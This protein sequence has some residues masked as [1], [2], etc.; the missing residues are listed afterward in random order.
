MAAMVVGLV[1]DWVGDWV[2][3]RVGDLA[4]G[5][6]GGQA[7]VVM[8]EDSEEGTAAGSEGATVAG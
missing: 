8:G 5:W 7:A 2:E 1:G 6:V 4:G 3:E